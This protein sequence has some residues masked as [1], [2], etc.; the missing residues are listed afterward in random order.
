MNLIQTGNFNLR[1]QEIHPNDIL[2]HL[3]GMFEY[4]CEK[5]GIEFKA[6]LDSEVPSYFCSD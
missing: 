1:L 4:S 3:R 2:E 6:E 5:K